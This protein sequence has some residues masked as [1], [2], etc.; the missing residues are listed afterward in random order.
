VRSEDVP[1]AD[2]RYW[3]N[4]LH[5]PPEASVVGQFSRM[6]PVKG[7]EITLA[8]A[9]SVIDRNPSTWFVV[10]GGVDGSR[11]S[12]EYEAKLRHLVATLGIQDR[13]VF[14]GFIDD[15]L[16]AMQA[17]DIVV[18]PS[19][20]E[21]LPISCLEAMLVQRPIVGSNIDGMG[22]VI[23]ESRCGFTIE[24]G[25]HESL[26]TH[27]S[28]LLNDKAMRERMGQNGR[29]WILEHSSPS[30]YCRRFWEAFANF[31]AQ[32]TALDHHN[33]FGRDPC[34]AHL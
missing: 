32:K 30:V 6:H 19:Y 13:I 2:T 22:E 33:Q 9:K 4:Q 11:D 14:P 34:R 20:S 21:G 23:T 12:Q 29:G 28:T 25:D 18:L 24:P 15:V 16:A 31:S 7:I 17:C 5:I 26:A 1:L 10:C 27:I 3:R 8:A